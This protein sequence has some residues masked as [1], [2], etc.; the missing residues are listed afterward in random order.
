LN[1]ILHLGAE[2][3]LMPW[4]E[5]APISNSWAEPVPGAFQRNAFQLNA[6]QVASFLDW[7]E[8]GEIADTWVEESELS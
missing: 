6:F 2:V 8:E 1:S 7:S 4:T 3:Y 5:E